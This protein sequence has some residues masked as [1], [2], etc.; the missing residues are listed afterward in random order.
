MGKKDGLY[1]YKE[2]SESELLLLF[3]E[4]AK[5]LPAI[6]AAG[7]AAK[8][9]SSKSPSRFLNV[10]LS[11]LHYGSDLKKRTHLLAY[12]AV[13]EARRTAAVVR[14]AVEYKTDKRDKTSLVLRINGD[15]IEGMLGHDDRAAAPLTMQMCRAEWILSQ[16]VSTLAANF[17]SVTVLVEWGNHGRNTLRHAGRADNDKYESF[18]LI[19]MNTVRARCRALKNVKWHIPYRAW[20]VDQQFNWKILQTHGD[21]IL[22]KSPQNSGF[23]SNVAK[24][25]SSRRYP[26]PFDIVVLGH[27]HVPISRLTENAHVFVNGALIPP[28]G[29]AESAGYLNE[30]AQFFVHKVTKRDEERA[31][32]EER[33][34]GGRDRGDC[35]SESWSIC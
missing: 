2:A 23:D 16:V 20:I 18:E 15:L 5:V 25:N 30:C 10:L 29:Y 32:Q 7:Y 26:G 8:K 13:E 35:D 17:P 11:D 34:D 24:L 31:S 14:N 9:A 21:T 6:P 12:G 28:N 27:W 1:Y 3:A 22:N 4:A 33:G 19:I